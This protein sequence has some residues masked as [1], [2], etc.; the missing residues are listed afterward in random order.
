MARL[1]RLAMV[2]SLVIAGN[3]AAAVVDAPSPPP[4]PS[5]PPLPPSR[6]AVACSKVTN[7][8]LLN[9]AYAA[10]SAVI[11]RWARPIESLGAPCAARV[12]LA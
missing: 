3:T 6:D 2:A 10:G 5:P 12:L 11:D 7:R 1:V 4:S 9:S 8:W